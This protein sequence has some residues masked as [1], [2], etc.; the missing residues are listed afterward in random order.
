M[1]L[2]AYVIHKSKC[3]LEDKPPIN[4][5]CSSTRTGRLS[6][7]NSKFEGK[8]HNKNAANSDFATLKSVTS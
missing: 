8:I 3:A 4:I 5:S 6:I 7:D 2:L 1:P